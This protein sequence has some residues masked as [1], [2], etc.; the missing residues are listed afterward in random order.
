M[1]GELYGIESSAKSLAPEERFRLRQEQSKHV[2]QRIHDW[3]LRTETLPQSSLGKAIAYMGGIWDGLRVFLD[4]PNVSID[5]NGTE[6]ALRGI[7]VGRKNHYGSRSRRGTEVAALFYS[8]IES[9]KLAGIGPHTYLKIA[10]DAALRGAE[11][12][13]P[14]EIV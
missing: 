2:V 10:A 13:L 7:V 5:N 6:R 12:P 11:I 9:T 1:I 3:A 4:D 8:L 14:H